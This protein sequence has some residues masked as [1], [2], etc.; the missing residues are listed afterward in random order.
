MAIPTSVVIKLSSTVK[1]SNPRGSKPWWRRS[2]Q[3]SY[4]ETYVNPPPIT[5]REDEAE[6]ASIR[7]KRSKRDE[8]ADKRTHL[9]RIALY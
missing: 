8:T 2:L 9:Q 5:I 4:Y 3:R 1:V 6:A 7:A